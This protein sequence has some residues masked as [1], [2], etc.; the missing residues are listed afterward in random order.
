MIDSIVSRLE[1]DIVLGRLHPRERLIED[2]LIDRFRTTRHLIRQALMELDRIGLVERVPN[3]GA[4]VKSYTTEEVEQLYQL[5][6]LLESEAAERIELPLDAKAL[7]EIKAIQAAHDSAVDRVDHA[8]IFRANLAFHRRLFSCCNNRF[9]A[10]AI[11][12][13]SQ[14]AHGIR[15]MSLMKQEERDAARREH[16][17]MIAALEHGDRQALVQLCRD[18]LPASK[19]AYI[20]TVAASA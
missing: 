12:A 8:A 13:A 15:F 2:E 20:R 9:L 1:E 7:A 16:H 3:R 6:E 5:R 10:D 14:R 18:H 19:N 17:A 11:E 4:M